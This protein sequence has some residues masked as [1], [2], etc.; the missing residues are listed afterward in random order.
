MVL[1][2]NSI[3]EPIGSV[4]SWLRH[5]NTVPL[6]FG[7]LICDG[8][9]VVDA[10]SSYNG[11][12]LPDFRGRFIRGHATLDNLNFGADTFYY[13]GGT[14]PNG[15]TDSHSLSHTHNVDAHNHSISSDGAHT[16][17]TNGSPAGNNLVRYDFALGATVSAGSH[18]HTGFTGFSSPATNAALTNVDNKP[19]FRELVVIIKIK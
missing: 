4:K 3:S 9:L 16:H 15:G 19:L 14:V 18:S 17:D 2:L 13:A 7:W 10:S 6:P 1:S 8:S 12:T 11:K 5:D